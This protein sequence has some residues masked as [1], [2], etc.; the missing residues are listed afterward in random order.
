MLFAVTLLAVLLTFKGDEGAEFAFSDRVQVVDIEGELVQS[1]PILAQLKRYEDALADFDKAL[2][3][4][5]DLAE[6]WVGKGHLLFELR[7]YDEASCAYEKA[8]TI[9]PDLA[10]AW[11]GRG[12]L[13]MA[14]SRLDEDRKSTR[15]N[16][17]HSRAS[18]MPSS[19]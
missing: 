7:R 11:Y 9:K 5:A 16:S 14:L 13:L 3:I 6:A 2:A 17:S 1:R 15:L 4:K 10:V 18:R 8:L 19:A 12:N